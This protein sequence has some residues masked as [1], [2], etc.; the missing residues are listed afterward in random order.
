[1]TN[2]IDGGDPRW[3]AP[4]PDK[5]KPTETITPRCVACGGVH[6]GINRK[7]AYL[8]AEIRGTARS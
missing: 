2:P 8:K 6:G 7:L 3:V 1:M 5:D 4:A